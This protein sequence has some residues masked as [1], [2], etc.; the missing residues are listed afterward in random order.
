M[1]ETPEVISMKPK[2]QFN[3]RRKMGDNFLFTYYM[4]F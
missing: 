2:S 1:E 3:L 4:A